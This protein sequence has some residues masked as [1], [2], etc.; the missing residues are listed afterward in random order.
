[1]NEVEVKQVIIDSLKD[2][3]GRFL[4]DAAK[5]LLAALGY[6]SQKR[7]PLDP[8]T[9]E[10]FRATFAHDRAFDAEHALLDDWQSVDLLF[11][12]TDEEIRSAAGD[13]Q[14]FLFESKGKWDGALIES[15]LFFA[16]ELR[17][18]VYTRTELSNITRAVNRLFLMPVI[19]LFRHGETI[20]LAVINRRQHRR[21]ESKDVLEKITLIKDIRFE[22]PHRAHVEVLFDLSLTELFNRFPFRNFVE[23][24]RAWQKTLDT[25]VLNKRFY[26]ELA[27]WYFWALDNAT[28]PADAPKDRDG[29]DSIS[30]IRLITRLIFCW[31]LK[32][33]ALI[34]SELFREPSVRALLNSLD[35]PENTYYTAI[36]QNLFFATLNTEMDEA[37][38]SP[39]RRFIDPNSDA[40]TSEHHMVHQ[41]WRYAERIRD[42]A[43]FERLMRA[44]PFLNGGLFECLDERVEKGSS[45]YTKEVRIDGFSVK[46]N[47]Q[48]KLPN[49]LFFGTERSADLSRAYGEPRYKQTKVWPIISLLD[50]YKFTVS[51]NTPI[52]E[53][54]ALDPELLGH[55]F[56]NLLAAY[57]PETDTVARKTTGSFY[58]PRVVVDFM[59][60]E[61]LVAYFKGAL[62]KV[63]PSQADPEPRL[64]QLLAYTEAKHEFRPAEVVVLVDAIDRVKVLDPACG[65]GAFPM[66]VLHKLV[67]VLGKLDPGNAE[68]RKRQLAKAR[69][70][71]VGRDAAIHAVED[72]FAQD[73]GDY[74]RK[75]YLIENCLYGV[76]IQPIAVQIA[77]L[78]CFISLVVEQE[79][80]DRLPNRG[81]LPLPNLETK[82]IA[83][84]TLFGVHRRGE[85]P[86]VAEDIRQKQAEL[87]S[88]RHEHFLARRY[89]EKKALRRHDRQLRDELAD[90]IKSTK[91]LS[92]P[93]SSM[94]ATWDPY[95]ADQAAPFFDPAWMFS[96]SNGSPTATAGFDI[97]I[98]NPP[99]VRQEEL[100]RLK[101]FEGIAGLV[102]P[103]KDALKDD[104]FCYSGVADLYVYFYERAFDLLSLGGVL[105]FISS[106]KYFRAGYGERL[107]YFLAASGEIRVLIDFGDAPVFTAI[108]Y[109]S[110]IVLKKTKDTQDKRTLGHVPKDTYKLPAVVHDELKARVLTWEPDESIEDFPE[111]FTQ[112]SF[113]FPQHELKPE[114]WRLESPKKLRLLEKLHRAGPPLGDYVKNRLYR[115]ILTGLNK[116]FVVDR[117]TRDRLISEHKSS[118]EVLKPFLRGRDVKRWRVQFD[119]QYLIKIE[120]SENKK[121]PW[122]SKNDTE[123]ELI[124][125]KTHPAVFEWLKEQRK[126]LKARYDQGHY[127]WELRSCDYWKQ[128]TRSKIVIPAIANDV[129]YAIDCDGYYS[130]DKTSICVVDQP[131]FVCALLNSKILWWVLRQTAATK[132]GGFYEFKPMYVSQLPIAVG[133]EELEARITKCAARL[134]AKRKVDPKAYVDDLEAEIDALVANF[135][136]LTEDE[137]RMVLEDLPL[138]APVRVGANNAFR[139][140]RSFLQ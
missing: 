116:A 89:A 57:N 120:S 112:S 1:M 4:A 49:F 69:Q 7:L 47:K 104:Y 115:G 134:I 23:L 138:T 85:M 75:L 110:I 26:Q 46:P 86:L 31:F 92:G 88:I 79:P 53:E 118:A 56:E 100:K 131:E 103:L 62:E 60:D 61:A 8:N 30:L 40:K 82:F 66:G 37:N 67:F 121:H 127:Y 28:F 9:P 10:T 139:D 101:A 15:Y 74:G 52:E 95:H 130:N 97:V 22:D 64:R 113:A 11:Q 73:R 16:I 19:L 71:D 124:F 25:S 78:R 43:T 6:Q 125:A 80:N 20:T 99:Y 109:P 126:A 50:R 18:P 122:S 58:T 55:V 94:V 140:T 65:S 91:M 72:A 106:N 36:L 107:R 137:F 111:T 35:D 51:E 29:R 63:F 129:E 33:K 84:N 68:W 13:R 38:K 128:F 70:L 132:Q 14:Q 136:G 42:R 32:E 39:T 3:R 102:Q 117:A 90:L 34:P 114:G 77:K 76:D 24:F 17:K 119:E 135:Y 81:V 59:V 41:V 98:G 54:V 133:N 45:N 83:A 93:E 5:G 2:F 105:C 96:L 44:I 48:P 108:S 27:N 21:D 12:L 123:A 87:R